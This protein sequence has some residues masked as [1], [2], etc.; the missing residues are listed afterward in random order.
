MTWVAAFVTGFLILRLI[1]S[2]INFFSRPLLIQ[3]NYS[4]RGLISVLIPARNEEKNL[5]VLLETLKQQNYKNLEILVYDDQ[6]TDSTP[7]IVK[8][9]LLNDPR[10]RLISGANPSHGWIGKNFAC[11]NLAKEANGVCFLFL[12]A[13]VVTAPS[14]ISSSIEYLCRNKLALLSIFPDQIMKSPGEKAT[15]PYMH[16]ILLTLLP[17]ISVRKTKNKNLSA[18][19]GQFMMF[20]AA[21]YRQFQFHEMVKRNPV[22][23]IQI[24]KI[25]KSMKLKVAT[26]LGNRLISCRMY[27]G[28][29]DALEGF[30]KNV[31]DFFGSQ[32]FWMVL[33]MLITTLGIPLVAFAWNMWL[34]LL[35][36]LTILLMRIA[37]SLSAH[38]SIAVNLIYA[39]PQHISFIAMCILSVRNR[40]RGSIIWKDRKIILP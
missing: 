22:E 40:I 7:E 1:V 16:W 37:V 31:A 4:D 20:E 13:D 3:R 34:G 6:S 27:G 39:I 5:P 19:N 17:L 25:M 12:D 32:Y 11:H 29:H 15:V 23:D 33:Y 9:F 26:L 14:L 24:M 18:A 35:Y 10:I 8:K 28:W 21:T 30:S 38:Q 2:L 36:L